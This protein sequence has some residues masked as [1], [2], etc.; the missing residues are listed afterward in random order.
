[1]SVND[2]NLVI[3]GPPGTGKSQ[4]IVN[5]I[6]EMLG[7]NKKILFCDEML[8]SSVISNSLVKIDPENVTVLIGPEG[9]LKDVERKYLNEINERLFLGWPIFDELGGWNV[10]T[11]LDK[12]DLGKRNQDS[13]VRISQTDCHPNK[14]GHE[15]IAEMLYNEIKKGVLN[16]SIQTT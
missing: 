16:G 4:T 2:K 7:S 11:W 10:D 3:E 1:M 15:K 9:G 6:A 5:L 8:N 13:D 14:K 12:V